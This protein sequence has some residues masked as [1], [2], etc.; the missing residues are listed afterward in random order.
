MTSIVCSAPKNFQYTYDAWKAEVQKLMATCCLCA[1]E[2]SSVFA[3]QCIGG[4]LNRI[5]DR[6]FTDHF[7]QMVD[8]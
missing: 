8:D 6:R 3:A 1:D 7:L 2:Q 4:I 5:D